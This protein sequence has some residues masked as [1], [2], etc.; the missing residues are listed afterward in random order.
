MCGDSI[1][2]T[3]EKLLKY[4]Y[5]KTLISSK[6]LTDVAILLFKKFSWERNVSF[7]HFPQMYLPPRGE[8]KAPGL[9]V[10]KPRKT[11]PTLRYIRGPK[12]FEAKFKEQ[13]AADEKTTAEELK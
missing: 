12:Y 7:L 1:Q 11:R 5:S 10:P 4:M 8:N 6:K 13:L 2:I 9:I 3:G